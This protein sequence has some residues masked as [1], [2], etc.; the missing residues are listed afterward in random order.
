MTT[1]NLMLLT[2]DGAELGR[3]QGR[4]RGRVVA[5]RL[6]D[7][8]REAVVLAAEGIGEESGREEIIA[9]TAEADEMAEDAAAEREA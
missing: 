4:A 7:E 8:R 6:A 3:V 9:P 1:E 2:D 5:Q